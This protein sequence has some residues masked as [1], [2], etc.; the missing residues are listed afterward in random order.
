MKK[1]KDD[2][3]KLIESI[4]KLK[5]SDEE[6]EGLM[7]LV[8]DIKSDLE[9]TQKSKNMQ[10]DVLG[11]EKEILLQNYIKKDND[12]NYLY[13]ELHKVIREKDKLT[14]DYQE[15]SN[16]ADYLYNYIQSIKR[17]KIMK[18]LMKIKLF[19]IEV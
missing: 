6:K 11:K 4:S 9:R 3:S 16:Y 2:C 18:F 13:K 19:K 1:Q 14:S 15:K 10:I 12:A 7:A 8:S 5:I 17:R